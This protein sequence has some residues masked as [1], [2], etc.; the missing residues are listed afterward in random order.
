MKKIYRLQKSWEFENVIKTKNQVFDKN[1]II[2]FKPSDNFKIGITVP[3]KFC[4]AVYR[5]Y[6]KRQLKSIINSLNFYNLK[7]HMVMIVRKNFLNISYAEKLEKTRKLFEKI[8]H[9]KK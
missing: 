4:N 1:L 8:Q 6:C 3:K 7:Y 9:G 5:N 2:Y